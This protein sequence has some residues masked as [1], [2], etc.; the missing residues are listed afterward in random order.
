MTWEAPDH[1]LKEEFTERRDEGYVVPESL[2]RRFE[3]FPRA[4]TIGA[5]T[6]SSRSTTSSCSSGR[7]RARGARAQP[8]R[9]HSRATPRRATRSRGGKPSDAE[10]LDRLHG[11]FTGRAVGCALGKPVEGMGMSH[12]NGR[13]SGARAHPTLPREPERLAAHR[14]LQRPRCG[15]RHEALVPGLPA[16][17]DCVHGAG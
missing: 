2:V 13:L 1:L 3:R 11:A 10:L 7:R 15:G 4:A 17:A 14:L 8:A 5:S 6:P 12:E 9:G 16:R